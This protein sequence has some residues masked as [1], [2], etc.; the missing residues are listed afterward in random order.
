[1]RLKEVWPDLDYT[2][3]CVSILAV[4][5]VNNVKLSNY[6]LNTGMVRHDKPANS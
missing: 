4:Q 5:L 1:M 6:V 2:I 3:E